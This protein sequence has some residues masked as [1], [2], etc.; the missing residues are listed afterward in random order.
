MQKNQYKTKLDHVAIATNDP[1]Q[2]KHIFKLI[3][4]LDGG[5][6]VIPRQGIKTHFL[7]IQPSATQ[8]EILEP[9]EPVAHQGVVAKFL[10]KRGPGVHHLSFEV[11]NLNE[12]SK[13]LELNRVKLVYSSSQS[14]A[15]QTKINFIHPDSTG[16]VL[17]EL[18]EKEIL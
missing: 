10:S 12:L 14:G 11:E 1:Q 13:E 5:T 7:K 2:L 16:G 4:L 6:E 17:I 9:V 18:S 15:H 3:G 8:I